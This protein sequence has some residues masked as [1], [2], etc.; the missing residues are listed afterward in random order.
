MT[1]FTR[2]MTRGLSQITRIISVCLRINSMA[3]NLILRSLY[4]SVYKY[5]IP[6]T[7]LAARVR[8]ER[9]KAKEIF[10]LVILVCIQMRSAK[11]SFLLSLFIPLTYAWRFSFAGR[12]CRTR[13]FTFDAFSSESSMCNW[14][15]RRR[16]RVS[17]FRWVSPM[18]PDRNSIR[19]RRLSTQVNESTWPN[20]FYS[21]L[22]YAKW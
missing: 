10:A 6:T 14:A 19:T 18:R 12:K 21:I 13:R 7:G 9:S 8:R 4:F 22:L 17:P 11:I 3:I 20:Y 16:L 5:V 15:Y 1:S 2:Q